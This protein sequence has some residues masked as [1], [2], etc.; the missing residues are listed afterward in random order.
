MA[1]RGFYLDE[2]G[3]LAKD[4]I[5][6]GCGDI[7]IHLALP[8]NG[9]GI[10]RIARLLLNRQGFTGQCRLID[11]EIFSF[12]KDCI[13]RHDIPQPDMNEIAGHEFPGRDLLPLP[14]TE[15]TGIGRELFF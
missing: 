2:P 4:G 8:G 10:Y 1:S 15:C 9:S 12:A 13:C 6:S 11:Q 5:S 3:G 7:C 14:V